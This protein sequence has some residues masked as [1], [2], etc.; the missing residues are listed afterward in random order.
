MIWTI[1]NDEGNIGFYTSDGNIFSTMKDATNHVASNIEELYEKNYR[2][3]LLY[4]RKKKLNIILS[5]LTNN[6][7]NL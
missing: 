3:N 7:T 4:E 1:R 2:F 5:R 6:I